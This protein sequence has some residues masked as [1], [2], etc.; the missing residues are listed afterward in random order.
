MDDFTL[1]RGNLSPKRS[2]VRPLLGGLLVLI[3]GAAGCADAERIEI[4]PPAAVSHTAGFVGFVFDGATG[5]RL[6]GYAISALAA[7]TDYDGTVDADGRYQLGNLSVWE[8]FTIIIEADGYR[9][10][11]SHNARVGLPPNSEGIATIPTHQTLHYDAYLFPTD[12]EAPSVVFNITTAQGADPS[13]AIRLRPIS[14]SLLADSPEETPSGVPGQLWTNDEDLLAGVVTK[15]FSG[16]E[17]SFGAGE[18]IYGVTYQ[19]DVYGVS[20]SQ[21]FTGFYTAG[22]EGGKTLELE[23]E[24]AEPLAV[25]ASTHEAC[26]PPT[27]PMSTTGATITIEL[28][29]P[30][31]AHDGAYPGGPAEAL[32]DGL[33][34]TSPDD[35]EDTVQNTLAADVSDAVQERGVTVGIAGNIVTISWNP[36]AGLA[37]IDPDD[38]ITQVTYGG[39]ANAVIR[40]VGSPSSASSLAALLGVSSI[41]CQ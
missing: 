22:V 19:V 15:N 31:E 18:L 3:A 1:S 25:V 37:T 26:S 13:G 28:N 5:A 24:V 9:A 17:A 8:D 33:S 36:S 34:I 11:Q 32:D 30:V 6:D 27:A 12:L 29:H 10:F 23:E 41:T 14:S 39:L 40:R 7:V 35:N 20:G 21:P 4:P 16:G 38:P 2:R